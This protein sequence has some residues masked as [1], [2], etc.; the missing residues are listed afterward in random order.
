MI[1]KTLLKQI[2]LDNRREIESYDIVHRDIAPEGFNCYVF[3]GVRRAGK[4]FV[5]YEKMQQLLR[6]GHSWDEML[7]LSFEDERLV[8]FT[9]EDFNAILESHIEM[10]GKDNPMLFLDEIHNID[11][12]EKFARRMAD[13]KLTVWITGSNA[14]MF[15]KEIMTT[16]GGRYIPIE[17]YPFS[18]REF[19][20][21]RNVP[22]DEQTLLSTTGRSLFLREYAEYLIWGGLPESTH[23]PVKRNYLSSVYQKI[24]LG[25][26][27][28]RN[29]IS[30]PNLLRLMVKK[31]SESVK[32]PL[33]YSRIAKILSTVGGK[34]T[35]PTISSYIEHCEDAWLLIRL[36]N[37]SAAFA[38]RE[39]N[40]KYYFIDNGL[41]SL[42]LVDPATTLLE[43][44]VA[45][46]L[47]RKYGNDKDNERVFFYNQNVEIDFYVPEDELAIQVSY[48]I[49]STDTTEGREVEAL[50]KLPKALSCKRRIIITYDEE[51]TIE[52]EYG[53]IEVIPCWKWLIQQ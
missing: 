43:N 1:S 22:C 20:R 25:D 23:L 9:Y 30:N 38:E 10:T 46:S 24:Y 33:S 40:S 13:S 36:H 48:S 18:F 6:D 16:L 21:S 29:K 53:M 49:E 28:A 5:L 47:F 35:V 51:K 8:G 42:L 52:D 39:T 31:M 17:V 3:V 27:C 11:G 50:Q 41:L 26:I 32:Q 37:I 15:S 2:L 7:Y 19:L 44:I 34:I 14:K 12:W 45:L 4:S